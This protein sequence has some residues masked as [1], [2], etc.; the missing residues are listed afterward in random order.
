MGNPNAEYEP[1]RVGSC[2]K[3]LDGLLFDGPHAEA[4]GVAASTG[5]STTSRTHCCQRSSYAALT[6]HPARLLRCDDV[7]ISGQRPVY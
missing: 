4:A 5:C 2:L 1:G 6:F 3:P 7:A